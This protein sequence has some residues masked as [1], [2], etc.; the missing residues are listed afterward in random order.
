[1]VP[2]S[3]SST[4]TLHGPIAN[5][6]CAQHA[7]HAWRIGGGGQSCLCGCFSR[8]WWAGPWDVRT[9]N[10]VVAVAAA[11]RAGVRAVH[12]CYCGLSPAVAGKRSDGKASK[13]SL[14]AHVRA[15]AVRRTTSSLRWRSTRSTPTPMPAHLVRGDDPAVHHHAC[16]ITGLGPVLGPVLGRQG[17]ALH[18]PPDQPGAPRD[19]G[20]H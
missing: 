6:A 1:M 13:G 14:C 18:A 10:R 20:I 15:I 16:N 8:Q 17:H 3:Q 5:T 11:P 19:G 7:L 4:S 2:G 12:V 9:R